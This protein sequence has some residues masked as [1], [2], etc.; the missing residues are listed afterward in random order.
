[1]RRT[2]GEKRKKRVMGQRVTQMRGPVARVVGREGLED[3]SEEIILE[4]SSQ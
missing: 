3:P 1:M 2:A 4:V